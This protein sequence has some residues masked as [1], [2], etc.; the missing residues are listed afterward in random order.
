M[1]REVHWISVGANN[2]KVGFLASE[3]SYEDISDIVGITKLEE[4]ETISLFQP[5]SLELVRQGLAIKLRIRYDAGEG[6]YKNSF[7]LCDIDKAPTAV[8][9][10]RGKP[11]KGGTI[12]SANITRRR[13]LG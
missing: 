10:L 7:V 6:Q 9:A 11:F 4:G 12:K 1:A 8:A 3:D 5:R 13:R 2:S